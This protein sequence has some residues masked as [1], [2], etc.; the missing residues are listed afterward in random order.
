MTES[1]ERA[2]DLLTL[3]MVIQSRSG[4]LA[5]AL[6]SVN[7]VAGHS[8][9]VHTGGGSSQ[10]VEHLASEY[11]A[12]YLRVPADADESS[13]LNKALDQVRSPWALFLNQQEVLH[14]AVPET[15]LD[16]LEKMAA[17]AID[18]PIVSFE[19]PRNFYFDTRLIRTDRALRWEHEAYPT[20]DSSLYRAARESGIEQPTA[21]MPHG[22]IISLGTPEPEEW[23]LRDTIIRV[24]R[25][26]DKNPMSV[27]Y[28]YHLAEAAREIKEWERAN[29]AVEEGLKVVSTEPEIPQQEPRAVCGLI[30]MLCDSLLAAQYYPEKTVES[31]WVIFGNMEGNGQLSV[32]L[33]RLLLAA[34]RPGDAIKVQY[35]AVENFFH[36]R[37]YHLSLEEGL[38]KP[39]MLAWELELELR[40]S[41]LIKSTVRIQTLFESRQLKMQPLLQFVSNSN[42]TLFTAIRDALQAGPDGNA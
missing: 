9:I 15:L 33:G 28:W 31:L 7:K 25:E 30:A 8:V 17:L 2:F 36:E 35:M 19:E 12:H 11:D 14:T 1:G 39:I 10:M 34:N 4:N 42:Q 18:F 6:H 27:R 3:C 22:A 26:L 5:N 20:L 24:E 40:R 41:E 32:P 29:A 37:R 16:W 38:Y 13:L 21:Y 23:E